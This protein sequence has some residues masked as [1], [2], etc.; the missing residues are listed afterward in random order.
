M[1]INITLICVIIALIAC[2]Y[3]S[4]TDI[5]TGIIPNKLTFP[6][7]F[8]G[9]ILNG[10]NAYLIGDFM[11]F[12]YALI[13]TVGIFILGYI[14]WRLGA[15]AGGDV[16]LFTAVAALLPFQ[17][18]IVNY[19]IFFNFPITAGYPFGLTVIINSILSILPFLL[20]F[21]FY[22]AFTEKQEIKKVLL[23]PITNYKK[24]L[25]QVLVVNTAIIL[26]VFILYSL[27]VDTIV[28]YII[29]M[30]ILGFAINKLPD[31]IK[32]AVVGL[33]TLYSLYDNLQLTLTAFISLYIS[34][35][36][37]RL[38]ILLLTTVNKLALQ[39]DKKVEE[40]EE[41]MIL[42]ND[43]YE[44][45]ENKLSFEE[46]SMFSKFK[47]AATTGDIS[48]LTSSNGKLVL[49]STAAGLT[50]KNI[51]FFKGIINDGKLENNIRVKR[52]VPFAPSILIGLLISLFIGDLAI[53]LSNLLNLI[54]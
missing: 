43:L 53:L 41:G 22:I 51:E 11:I 14:F 5:T 24:T 50:D 30:F 36:F 27:K 26:A 39:D 6:L 32:Y 54:F 2:I 21:V 12:V 8:V 46:D 45:G 4:Y 44:T 37:V 28:L 20:I 10:V 17:P 47:T 35:I 13:F 3:A 1:L 52:G 15:W 18:G 49:K 7:M 23:E 33:F 48:V 40:L 19:T 29:L 42:A 9:L 25:S 31:K 38:I 34:I 16:K